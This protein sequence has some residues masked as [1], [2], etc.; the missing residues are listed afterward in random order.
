V[1]L[2]RIADLVNKNPQTSNGLM[3]F[4]LQPGKKDND[5]PK[6]RKISSKG[7]VLSTIFCISVHDRSDFFQFILQLR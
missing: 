1:D 7:F 5:R 4:M 6:K 3:K 2:V